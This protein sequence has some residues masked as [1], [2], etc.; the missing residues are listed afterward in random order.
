VDA[1]LEVK[2]LAIAL[3]IHGI[4]NLFHKVYLA[5]GQNFLF[6]IYAVEQIA[7]DG[8]VSRF[9]FYG[10][11]ILSLLFYSFAT[12]RKMLTC[13]RKPAHKSCLVAVFILSS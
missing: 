6:F 12:S 2:T 11:A 10:D 13:V 3:Q 4:V 8:I 9:L 5:T 7:I 1:I